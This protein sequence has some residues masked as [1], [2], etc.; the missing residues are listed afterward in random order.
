MILLN[1][2]LKLDCLLKLVS[3]IKAIRLS[4]LNLLYLQVLAESVQEH[5]E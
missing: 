2:Q 4:Y 3:N 1:A 5:K